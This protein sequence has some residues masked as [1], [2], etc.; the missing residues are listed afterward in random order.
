MSSEQ[1]YNN[2]SIQ[3][4]GRVLFLKKIDVNS[5]TEINNSINNYFF[6]PSF[7][8]S[9]DSPIQVGKKHEITDISEIRIK[10]VKRSTLLNNSSSLK[11]KSYITKTEKEK[12]KER[13]SVLDK[14]KFELLDNKKLKNVFDSF[15]DKINLKKKEAYLK[16]NNSDLPLNINVSLRY[17]QDSMHKMKLNKINKENLERYLTKKSKKNKSDL[18][19]NKIDN[20]LYKKEI[21]KN[22]ENKKIISE[23]NSRK[24]WILSLRRPIKLKG[25]R[26]SIININTDK[27]PF[28]GYF[29]EKENE[30]K[31]TSVKPGIN[32]NSDYIKKVLNKARTTN[33]L[34]EKNI[35]KL[36]NLDELKIEGN[37]LLDI[38]YKREMGSQKKKI[39]HKA[40]LDNGR[41]IFKTDINNVFG[42][43]TF[44]KNYDKNEYKP[45]N[46]SYK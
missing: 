5:S 4:N 16:Y 13:I 19:F 9:N 14:N 7:Y 21:F 15:K 3:K 27:Y 36:K 33:S 31:V 40:F 22:I 23:N 45:I 44:Y 20:Y 46:T 42:K 35:K 26:R 30:L 18:L 29:I 28:W 32:L 37:D 34:N 10:K 1:S 17:Q 8:F 38:E 2:K 11:S 24:D 43:Q 25:I 6:N 39:L 41:I 12:E